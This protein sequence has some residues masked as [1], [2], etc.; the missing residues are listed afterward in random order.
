MAD[1][2]PHQVSRGPHQETVHSGGGAVFTV[3]PTQEQIS[4]R[5]FE[6]Y[7]ASGCKEGRSEQ[8]W[9]QAERELLTEAATMGSDLKPPEEDPPANFPL[10]N[11]SPVFRGPRL[12]LR[13][14]GTH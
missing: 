12:K 11:F 1:T 8:N 7:V 10:R 9:L 13:P 14:T 2:T 3:Q 6:I 5:A 4:R